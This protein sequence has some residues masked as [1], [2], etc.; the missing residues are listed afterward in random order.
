MQS[1]KWNAHVTRFQAA[2]APV[3]TS[4]ILGDS[5]IEQFP[6]SLLGFD[7]YMN[8]GIGG[9]FTSTLLGRLAPLGRLSPDYVMLMVGVND[10]VANESPAAVRS[11]Y[12]EI[13][14]VIRRDCPD[15]ELLVCSCLPTSFVSGWL[16]E[17]DRTNQEV[18]GLNAFLQQRCTEPGTRFVNVYPL[19]ESDGQLASEFTIDGIHLN[20]RGYRLWARKV[21]DVLLSDEASVTHAGDA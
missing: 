21:R 2:E 9:E 20:E 12:S 3:G 17:N 8:W 5:L 1:D 7:D 16:A 10:I 11:N 14:K 4:I 19:L 15:T 18:R 13:I 6:D